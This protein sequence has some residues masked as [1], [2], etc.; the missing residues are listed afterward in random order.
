M[1]FR[2][3]NAY[4]APSLTASLTNRSD[5]NITEV[6]WPSSDTPSETNPLTFVSNHTFTPAI[7]DS[8]KIIQCT[9]AQPLGFI[10]SASM[11]V[12]VLYGPSAEYTGAISFTEGDKGVNISFV[13]QSNPAAKSEDMVWVVWY[14]ESEYI[15]A[16]LAMDKV[17]E[18]GKYW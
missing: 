3:T 13:V 4:P 12:N 6:I 10:S 11:A 8:G 2:A 14:W 7:E 9:V 18:N 16:K 15:L 1:L 5:F 17:T